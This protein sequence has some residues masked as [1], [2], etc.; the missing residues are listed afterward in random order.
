MSSPIDTG[1]TFTVTAATPTLTHA[2][3]QKFAKPED[4]D[5]VEALTKEQKLLLKRLLGP[6]NPRNSAAALLKDNP[7]FQ[8]VAHVF[9]N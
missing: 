7:L 1:N 4:V 8:V 6:L 3:G 5:K 2:V 9:L